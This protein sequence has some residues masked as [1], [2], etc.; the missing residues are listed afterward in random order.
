MT[1]VRQT[2]PGRLIELDDIVGQLRENGHSI[3]RTRRAVVDGVRRQRGAFT[4]DDLA[5]AVPDVHVAT[6]YRT[7]ALL[8]EIGAVRHTHLSHGP[9]VYESAAAVDVRHLVCEVCGRHLAVP[10]SIFGSAR[11]RLE[12]DYDFLLDGSHFAVVGRCRQC[13]DADPPPMT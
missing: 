11:K 5:A 1:K 2:H 13:A 3:G 7:L 12:R 10:S 9:A 8:E 4:A 6:V